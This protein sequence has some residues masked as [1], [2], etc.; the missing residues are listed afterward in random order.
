MWLL[1]AM[2]LAAS[3]GTASGPLSF[4]GC[5]ATVCLFIFWIVTVRTFIQTGRREERYAELALRLLKGTGLCAIVCLVIAFLASIA[6]AEAFVWIATVCTPWLGGAAIALLGCRLYLK[7]LW[8][9]RAPWYE[10]HCAECGY[11]LSGNLD[12]S[13]CSECGTPWKHT[14]IVPAGSKRAAGKCDNCGYDMSGTPNADKCPECGT[15]WKATPPD[16]PTA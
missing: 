15:G 12:A 8:I 3:D 11:D 16:A 13:T 1:I 10:T 4:L 5:G 6:T 14:A 7:R 9:V 2:L